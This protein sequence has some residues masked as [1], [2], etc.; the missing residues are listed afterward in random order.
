MRTRIHFLLSFVLTVTLVG[1]LKSQVIDPGTN[2]LTHSWTFD[3]GTA[4]D[5]VGHANGKLVGGATIS[6]GALVTSAQGQWMEIP[7]DSI[8]VNSYTEITLEAWYTPNRGANPNFTMLAFFGNTQSSIGVNYYFMTAARLDSVSRTAISCNNSSTPWSAETGVNGTEYDDGKLHH[9][10]STFTN[11]SIKLYIDG[12]LTGAKQLDTNNNISRI[13]RAFAYLAKS[14]YT[15]DAQWIGRIHEFNIYNKALDSTQVLFLFQKGLPG[16]KNLTHSWTFDDG[17]ANDYVGHANGTLKGNATISGGSLVLS[18]QGQ[19]MEMPGDVINL[20]AHNEITLEAWYTPTKNANPNFTMLAFFGNT[21]SS[22][23]V[24]YYFMTAARLDSVSRTAISCNNS[25]TPWSAETGVNGTEYDDGKLHHMVSTLTNDSIK[26]YIDGALTGAKQLDTNNNISRISRAF[27]YLAKSG[28]TG[29]AQWIGR[30]HEFNIYNKAL[31]SSEVRFLY[32]KGVYTLPGN[33]TVVVKDTVNVWQGPALAAGQYKF[34][35]NVPNE[36]PENT[37]INYWTQLTPGNAGK[38]GSVAGSTD[39]SKWY[40]GTLDA[41]YNYAITNHLVY[42]HHNLIWGQQ[43]PSWISSLD[44]ATQYNYIVTWIRDVG[45]RYP[46]MDMVDVVNE[47]MYGHNPPDGGS[48]RANYEN[49]LGGQGKTGWDWLITAYKLARKY[50]PANTKLLINDYGII[51]DN[52]ATTSY[53]QIINLLQQG[54]LI[55]GIGV[56]G[57]RFELEGGDTV[58]FKNNLDRLGATGLPVYISEFDLGN[59]GDSGIS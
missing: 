43:Q 52:V 46:K 30:I 24:N 55:D 27:A 36:P 25:S 38:W 41:Q 21:Q 23:G 51:N 19:W 4:N 42:K 15:G 14:G 50:M 35:G 56:Q 20:P 45:Q 29:D 1:L 57:H 22:V 16:T 59:I 37:F 28:Y 47:P 31:D 8:A 32:Q 49:A 7:A 48:G 34:L 12:A 39:T 26:L 40:W 44:S 9:M 53:L 17:T 11:D 54:G 13:S 10:V 5:Y 58:T 33:D 2:N 18:A 6:G 3:D